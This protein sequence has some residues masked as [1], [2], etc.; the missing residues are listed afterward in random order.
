MSTQVVYMFIAPSVP[1]VGDWD[2][3]NDQT[4]NAGTGPAASHANRMSFFMSQ[5][6][7]QC[8]PVAKE[9]VADVQRRG[10]TDLRIRDGTLDARF[11]ILRHLRASD[12]G[13]RG[14]LGHRHRGPQGGGQEQPNQKPTQDHRCLH[15]HLTSARLYRGA[16][17]ARV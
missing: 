2:C 1:I 11:G 13:G 8:F 12:I 10:I 6:G 17:G 4:G 15:S 7:L 9:E 14:V 16:F 5:L 3:V